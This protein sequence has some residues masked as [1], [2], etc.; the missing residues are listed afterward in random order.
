[1][2]PELS[3][4]IAAA[5][6]AC[7]TAYVAH[8]QE[9][10]EQNRLKFDLFERR[11]RIYEAAKNLLA[12]IMSSGRAQQEDMYKFKVATREAKW[13]LNNKVAEYLDKQLY[14]KALYL[15]TLAAE[16][17]GVPVGEERTTNVDKQRD[18]KLWFDEQFEILDEYFAPFLKLE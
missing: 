6:A 18:I 11:F 9:R 8:R 16:L 7:I 2:T 5:I 10:L 15:Q 14:Y 12:S 1:M 13:L 3:A 17:E 4:T